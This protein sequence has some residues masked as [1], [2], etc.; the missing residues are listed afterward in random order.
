MADQAPITSTN[1]AM[2]IAASALRAQQARMKVIAENIANA[3]ST[4][5]A[6]GGEIG[7]AHV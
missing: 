7:R 6:A 5:T 4:S 2:S 1:A 3:D